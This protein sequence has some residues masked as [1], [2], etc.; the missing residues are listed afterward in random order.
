M[1]MFREPAILLVFYICLPIKA[2]YF[3]AL[4]AQV[5]LSQLYTAQAMS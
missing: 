2:G 1:I 5:V 3:S 4:V